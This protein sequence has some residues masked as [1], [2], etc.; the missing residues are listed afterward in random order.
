MKTQHEPDRQER[1][2][3]RQRDA[4]YRA[5]AVVRNRVLDFRYLLELDVVG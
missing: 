4:V 1:Q 3:N 2:E 5:I